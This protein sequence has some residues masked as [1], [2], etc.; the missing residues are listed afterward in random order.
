MERRHFTNFDIA[1]FSYYDGPIAFSELKIG[2]ELQ[3]V[4][5]FNN[6]YDPKAVIIQYKEYKLG[7]VPRGENDHISKLLEMG[8]NPF[9]VRIQRI[10]PTAKPEQQIGLVV[11]LKKA[12]RV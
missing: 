9:E 1:G 3:L 7:Y 12:D 8:Y 2:T 4:P 11:Y 10:D 5:E 6:P